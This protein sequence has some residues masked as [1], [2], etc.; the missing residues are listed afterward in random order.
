MRV[1]AVEK[2]IAFQVTYIGPIPQTIT[3]DPTRLRQVLMSLVGKALKFTHTGSVRLMVRL[4]N[5]NSLDKPQLQFQVVDTGIGMTQEQIASLF[6]PFAP[7]DAW[8][9][10]RFGG[11]GLGL[12][13]S[14]RL[15]E[16][17]GGGILVD[18]ISGAGTT[19][20]LSIDPGPLTGVELI[21]DPGEGDSAFAQHAKLVRAAGQEQVLSGARILIAEDGPDNQYLISLLLRRAGARISAVDNG[22]YAVGLALDARAEVV[23]PFD[24]ILMDMQMPEMDGHAATRRL[25]ERGYSGKILALT[26]HTMPGDRERC[27][28][29]GCDAYMPKPFE[30]ER[31]MAAVCG[32]LG[33]EVDCSNVGVEGLAMELTSPERM[34]REREV[35]LGQTPGG[36]SQLN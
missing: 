16:A 31:L 7:G 1:R 22:R 6:R 8:T 15:A 33:R 35:Q 19:F 26:A 28:A 24:L 25:R 3:S 4:L 5:S 17:M 11:T 32:A 2:R 12:S 9:A 18:S 34:A 14:K 23:Q 36:R 20:T 29:D 30:P 27:L 13:I 21:L 10:R